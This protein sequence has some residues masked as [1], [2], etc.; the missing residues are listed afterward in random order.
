MLSFLLK[1]FVIIFWSFLVIFTYYSFWSHKEFFSWSYISYLVTILIIYSIYKFFKIEFWL[2][3]IKYSLK[4]L[5]WYF[6]LHLFI[7]CFLY[8]SYNNLNLWDSLILFFKI[9]SFLVVPTIILFITT[10]FWEKLLELFNLKQQEE[11]TFNLVFSIWLGF[12]IFVSLVFIIG[13]L[14]IY[15]LKSVLFILLLLIIFSYKN[16][17]WLFKRTF[18]FN[19]EIDNHNLDSNNLLE[20]INFYLLSSEFLFIVATLIISVN[21][22]SIV[23]PMPI[24]W[25]DLWVYMNY[26]RQMVNSW[27]VSFLGSMYAWQIFTWIWFMIYEP[28]QAF[29]FNNVWGILSFILIIL[30]IND[31]LKSTKK[32][33]INYWLLA[34]TLFIS[35]PMVIFQQAKDMKLDPGL[36]AFTLTSLYLA[37][38]V[39]FL[40]YLDIK[41]GLLDNIKE[42]FNL[43]KNEKN[44]N[45]LKFA[46]LI[47]ILAW[48]AFAIKFTSLLLIIWLLAL[49]F[50]SKLWWLG[51]LS[52]LFIF[53]SV[54]TKFNL[55]SKLN[56]VYD[57]SDV[58]LINIISLF[59]FLIW[60]LFLIW[61]IKKYSLKNFKIVFSQ[62][63]VFIL[64]I[65][66]I[67]S[68]WFYKNLSQVW[69]KNV[70]IDVL[71]SWKQKDFKPD[72]SKLYTKDELNKIE[73]KF[74]NEWLNSSWTTTNEDFWRYFGYEKWINNYVK[75]PWNL[76]MQVN[77]GWE[78]T[79]IW[80]IFLAL[81]PGLL[82]FLPYRKRFFDIFPIILIAFELALFVIPKSKEYFTN[83]MSSL[84]LPFWYIFIFLLFIIPTLYFLYALK[85]TK[86]M[87]LFKVNLVFTALYTLLWSLAAYW[88]VW[89]WIMMYFWML[90]MI[91]ISYT[92]LASYDNEKEDESKINL[93][94]FGTLVIFFIISVWFFMSVFPHSFNNLKNAWYNYVKS[95]K[96][97]PNELIFAYHPD[98]IDI[99]ST[100]N[101]DWSKKKELIDD[102]LKNKKELKVILDNFNY[103][104]SK[105][106][107]V[108]KIIESWMLERIVW[109]DIYSRLTTAQKNK[110]LNQ[111]KE[112]KKDFYSQILNPSKKYRNEAI[113]YRIWTFLKYF[114]AWNDHRLYEDSL[115]D[116]YYR[117]FDDKNPDVSVEKMKKLWLKYLLVDLN[118]A[119]IDRDPRH[120]LTKRYE[121]LLYTFTSPKLKLISTDSVCLK[122][123]REEYFY[124]KK[125]KKDKEKYILLAW[126]NSESY[127]N[128]KT[129]PR[130][131]K[132]MK[133]Y[134]EIVNL[135]NKKEVSENK[136]SYLLPLLRTL[137]KEPS[138]IKDKNKFYRFLYS[139]IRPWSKALFE[140]K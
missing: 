50:Y 29:F 46:F 125:T 17:I 137:E 89:Y 119:T 42:K 70:N 86:R 66:V 110:I 74:K 80:W 56:I 24:G 91:M 43:L 34:W 57:K 123:A 65:F 69:F 107:E 58:V 79:T 111:A 92:Y 128:W 94:F 12:S 73:K 98:Y 81:I 20:K 120:N 82:L 26:P 32:A 31:L 7:L 16:I 124:S 19:I 96:M 126:V 121:D 130:W 127:I 106:N 40:H 87:V 2:Y 51:F 3:K 109:K 75:L 14:G 9:I 11:K 138:L 67:L 54:F 93:K 37:Y 117:Y 102:L 84:T 45:L 48:F 15:N 47:W 135:I 62:V 44:K 134:E 4:E 18:D 52:Y 36:F 68:P 136:Y 88:V 95:W 71:L 113:I 55:W 118:A 131:E 13:L 5:I 59:S 6:L 10:W 78:F 22:I 77:Q 101:I 122:L 64:W 61:A 105:I 132:L 104:Y 27:N 28:I 33:F 39:Y 97:T 133:C 38:K 30:V 85:N 139:R 116:K 129:I 21:L 53:I 35:M 99:L 23:R 1:L 140:I 114:I 60:V 108:L 41:K 90:L 8:Y 76:T 115:V 25:D 63:L 72:Y 103:D 49:I 112:F 100:L 83:L